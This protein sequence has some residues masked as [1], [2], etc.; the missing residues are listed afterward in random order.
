M[1]IS[2]IYQ[3]Y[4]NI[5]YFQ[6][7]HDIFQ[8]CLES[9]LSLLKPF[10]EITKLIS[11][12]NYSISEV[13]PSIATLKL[14]LEKPN[15]LHLGVGIMKGH[16]KGSLSR[17]FGSVLTD[18]NYTIATFL[19]PRYKCAFFGSGEEAVK[20]CL[21]DELLIITSTQSTAAEERE[22]QP[23]TSSAVGGSSSQSQELGQAIHSSFWDCFNELPAGS[24]SQN[25]VTDQLT[26]STQQRRLLYEAEMNIYLL[27]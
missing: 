8:L 25:A 7:Y 3:K 15:D 10:E 17:R 13:I 18:K 12:G 1:K 4:Q 21:L 5:R 9:V 14:F 22:S 6:K 24:P 20:T 16:L 11:S 19:D 27:A 23:Q 26:N 2:D